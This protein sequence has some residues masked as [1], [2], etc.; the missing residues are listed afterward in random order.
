MDAIPV[1]GRN[2]N[3]YSSILSK[4]GHLLGYNND[5]G[6]TFAMKNKYAVGDEHGG[7]GGKM[8][9]QDEFFEILVT[10]VAVRVSTI[11]VVTTKLTRGV[12]YEL[13]E[14]QDLFI[15]V[16]AESFPPPAYQWYQNG[17]KLEGETR[18]FLQVVGAQLSHAGAYTCQISNLA[19]SVTFEDVSVSVKKAPTGTHSVA[20]AAGG[21]ARTLAPRAQSIHQAHQHQEEVERANP[22]S[23]ARQDALLHARTQAAQSQ[24]L[25]DELLKG[26]Y[27]NL[28]SNPRPVPPR[29]RPDDGED[30]EGSHGSGEEAGRRSVSSTGSSNLS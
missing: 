23:Q 8:M 2:R 10:Q 28:N 30:S 14:G 22:A 26:G 3:T 27:P 9:V 20:H 17:N 12:H 21:V 5:L 15:G 18:S 16:S 29:R 4:A 24:A 11:P 25:R 1:S 19:G 7:K 6:L 13:F